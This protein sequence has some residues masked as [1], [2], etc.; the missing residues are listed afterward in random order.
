MTG[1]RTNV[2]CGAV[3]FP[4]VVYVRHL[5]SGLGTTNSYFNKI[6]LHSVHAVCVMYVY[7]LI[8]ECRH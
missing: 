3:Y 6:L 2:T 8:E 7:T 1:M 4:G 5:L